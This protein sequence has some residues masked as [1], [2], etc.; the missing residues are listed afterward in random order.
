MA[1]WQLQ[2]AKDRFSE[3]IERALGE[4]PQMMAVRGEPVA[5]LIS[6]AEDVRVTQPKPR[7]VKFV[8]SSPRFG[9]NWMLLGMRIRRCIAVRDRHCGYGRRD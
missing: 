5:V 3:V 7:F 1:T 8:R 6:N 2:E 9:S 4:G